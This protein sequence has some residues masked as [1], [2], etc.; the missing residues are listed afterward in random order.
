MQLGNIDRLILISTFLY[1]KVC[2]IFYFYDYIEDNE[3]IKNK[4]V[5]YNATKSIKNLEKN[6]K[7][8]T[9]TQDYLIT[10]WG[11]I[12]VNEAFY[13]PD[14]EFPKE[15][16]QYLIKLD[17]SPSFKYVSKSRD[18]YETTSMVVKPQGKFEEL[19][20]NY[21]DNLPYDKFINFIKSDKSG[22]ALMWGKAG[23]GKSN[24]LRHMIAQNPNNKFLWMDQSA[25]YDV[26]TSSFID[27]LLSKKNSIIILIKL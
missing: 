11:I 8:I 3:S 1:N 23:T 22:L 21:N 24:L 13:I 9:R 17:K 19:F 2:N 10:E 6:I 12:D 7:Y 20:N 18:Y 16:E 14:D 27:F 4:I 25:L 5:G 26:N 15:F